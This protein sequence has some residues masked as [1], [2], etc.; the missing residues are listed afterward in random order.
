MA[1]QALA[2][3]TPAVDGWAPA[4]QQKAVR[5]AVSHIVAHAYAIA[6]SYN[7]ATEETQ[8]IRRIK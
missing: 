1:L 4:L 6:E 2:A 8:K 5:S 7:H 3:D